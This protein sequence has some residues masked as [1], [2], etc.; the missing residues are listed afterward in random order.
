MREWCDA[1]GLPD[2]TSHGLRKLFMIRL[3]HAGY[4]APQIAALSGHKDLREIQ[5]YIDEY[6]RQKVGI[7]TSTAFEQV[8]N[9]NRKL[10]NLEGRLAN[11][12]K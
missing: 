9:A 7:E 4:T 12:S 8:R 6:D 1:A 5:T 3:V 10:A 11:P 2:C